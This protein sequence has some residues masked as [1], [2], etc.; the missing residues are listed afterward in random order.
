MDG[1]LWNQTSNAWVLATE[2]ENWRTKLISNLGH[3]LDIQLSMSMRSHI[4]KLKF[5]IRMAEY[6]S[7][8]GSKKPFLF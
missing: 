5:K 7:F 4:C 8:A 1:T 6:S 2:S 3:V